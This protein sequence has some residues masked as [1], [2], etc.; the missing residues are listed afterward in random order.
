MPASRSICNKPLPARRGRLFAAGWALTFGWLLA[1]ALGWLV[2]AAPACRKARAHGPPKAV[3]VAE[4]G[5]LELRLMTFNVRYETGEDLGSR[6]WRK[7]VP[8][9]I[10]MIHQENPDVIGIQ[11]A[12]HGQAADLWASLPEFDFFGRAREDGHRAG[13]YSGIFYRRDRLVP[14]PADGGTFW[15]SDTPEKPGSKTWGNGVTRVATWLR[16]TDRASQR[17]F[18]VFNTHWDHRH[19]GSREKAAQLL[20]RR[21]DGRRDPAAPVVLMGDFNA[22]ETNPGLLIL[23]GKGGQSP[24]QTLLIETFQALHPAIK[25]RRTLHFWRGSTDG[26]LKVDHI[27][28][29]HGAKILSA[30]IRSDDEPM[31]SDHF[32]VTAHVIFP[33]EPSGN[34]ASR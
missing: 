32:P 23:T 17:P 25:N 24:P 2:L 22:V 12:L 26:E 13:E 31:V 15:L 9:I 19:Q 11:E 18:Y 30:A 7:R 33:A 5:G 4:D 14:D 1:L 3:P 29:S 28:V 6:A 16:F 8:G 27:L 10:R 21:I 20:A 34:P